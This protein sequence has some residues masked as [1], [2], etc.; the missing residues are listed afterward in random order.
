M[1]AFQ[2]NVLPLPSR[3]YIPPKF[4]C[5]PP[6]QHSVM[7][8]ALMMETEMVPETSVLFKQLTD[9]ADSPRRFY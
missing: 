6:R 1:P 4:W 8:T 3:Q 2:R 5:L 9:M 7:G